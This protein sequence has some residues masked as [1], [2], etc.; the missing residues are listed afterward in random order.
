MATGR[1]PHGFLSVLD[2]AA[3]VRLPDTKAKLRRKVCWKHSA[4]LVIRRAVAGRRR[5]VA[6]MQ[7]D[8]RSVRRP[9]GARRNIPEAALAASFFSATFAS[10][11]TGPSH[12]AILNLICR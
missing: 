4:T 5:N 6:G 9:A 3:T 11:T 7:Y 12:M 8:S 2:G 10:A 1:I